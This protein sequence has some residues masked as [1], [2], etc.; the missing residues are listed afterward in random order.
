MGRGA[1]IW[2]VTAM[3]AVLGSWIWTAP[4]TATADGPVL[5]R[6]WQMPPVMDQ[7]AEPECVGYAWA[8]WAMSEPSPIRTWAD[9]RVIYREAQ[10]IDEWPGED[11][12]GTSTEAGA[13]VLQRYGR[14]GDIVDMADTYEEI[15]QWLLFRG[16]VVLDT[17]L[18][19][20]MQHTRTNGYI[21]PTGELVGYHAYYLYDIRGGSVGG[22]NSWG[23]DW[24]KGGHF[25]LSR[26]ALEY[27]L[28]IG[29]TGVLATYPRPAP[30]D[31]FTALMRYVN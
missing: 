5:V 22:M 6:T 7:G 27:L 26:P 17:P 16:P 18:F 28:D 15:R 4:R 23:A 11:Y 29:A 8:A 10:F 12:P 31:V 9:P 20:G 30:A 19:Q 14:L 21:E 2:V 3:L 24:G 13:R 25:R 1:L